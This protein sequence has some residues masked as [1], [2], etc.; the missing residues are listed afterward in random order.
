MQSLPALFMRARL[1]ARPASNDGRVRVPTF[2]GSSMQASSSVSLQL[3]LGAIAAKT[4]GKSVLR[5]VFCR[6]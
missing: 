2:A 6:L 1:S 4:A 5:S 3:M